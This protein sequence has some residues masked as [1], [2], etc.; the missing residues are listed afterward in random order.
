MST[1]INRMLE[2]KGKDGN[3]HAVKLY[4]PFE[5]M[6]SRS[7]DGTVIEENKPDVCIPNGDKLDIKYI[8]ACDASYLREAF[9]STWGKCKD[10]TNRGIPE[11]ISK[12]LKTY[13]NGIN[14]DF[15]VYGWTYIT[16]EELHTVFSNFKEN[17]FKELSDLFN[18]KNNGIIQK[19]LDLLIK[20]VHTNGNFYSLEQKEISQINRLTKGIEL[21]KSWTDEE[22]ENDINDRIS[23]HI[24]EYF[25]EMI[26]ISDEIANIE[27]LRNL[28]SVNK[29]GDE[30][31]VRIIIFF[32]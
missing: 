2:A 28:F 18:E 7:A 12:E 17:Y 9:N 31:R 26:A 30:S 1:Y 29:Y 3:W 10:Y 32:D 6:V 22:D 14:K 24:E 23:Y 20:M 27:R 19:K 21:P 11:D 8:Y 4:K 13:I 25:W 5:H 15:G 16:L